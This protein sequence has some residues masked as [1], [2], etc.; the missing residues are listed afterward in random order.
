MKTM[1]I[2]TYGVRCD[3]CGYSGAAGFPNTQKARAF[4][5]RNG[6]TRVPKH[7]D[8]PGEDRCTRCT[9]RAEASV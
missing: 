6:W 1:L 4:A 7:N 8:R 5:R 2:K 9:R 3:S